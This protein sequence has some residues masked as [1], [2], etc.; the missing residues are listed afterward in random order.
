MWT[1]LQCRLGLGFLPTRKVES[2]LIRLKHVISLPTLS[3]I[4]IAWRENTSTARQVAGLCIDAA[5]HCQVHAGGVDEG[6]TIRQVDRLVI[7]P[8]LLHFYS[9]YLLSPS[10]PLNIFLSRDCWSFSKYLPAL[11]SIPSFT[12]KSTPALEKLTTTNLLNRSRTLHS[13]L[14]QRNL[15]RP[16]CGQ[17]PRRWSCNPRWKGGQGRDIHWNFSAESRYTQWKD[18]NRWAFA[19]S[20]SRDG[21]WHNSLH[22]FERKSE[23]LCRTRLHSLTP[24]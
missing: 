14:V 16:T 24:Q 10:F 12:R 7:F 19:L 13:N 20:P 23:N 2:Y 1:L 21:S 3:T 11:M 17:R 22:W 8:L 15:D 6:Q 5:C 4:H 18:G 9:H